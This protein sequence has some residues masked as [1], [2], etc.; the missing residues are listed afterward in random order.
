MPIPPVL[1]FTVLIDDV[2]VAIFV[3]FVVV[4]PFKM[5]ILVVCVDIV[6]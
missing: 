4:L 2:L 1:V 3:A 6:L 5:F